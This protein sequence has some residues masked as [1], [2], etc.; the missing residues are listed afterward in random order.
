M[1]RVRVKKKVTKKRKDKRTGKT[2]EVK[3]DM[4]GDGDNCYTHMDK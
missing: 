2:I 1:T 4:S 3:S